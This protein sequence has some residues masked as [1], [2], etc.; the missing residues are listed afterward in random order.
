MSLSNA[1]HLR[2]RMNLTFGG[3][4]GNEESPYSTQKQVAVSEIY[5]NSFDEVL[6]GH[7]SHVKVSFYK[8]GSFEVKDNGRGLPTD[9]S[10]DSNGIKKSGVMLALGTIQAGGKFTQEDSGSYSTGLNGVGASSVMVVADRADIS[11]YRGGKE[12]SLSFKHGEPGFFEGE[13]KD[14]KFKPLG[15]D[16]TK[17]HEA[18]DSR[19]AKDKKNYKTGTNIKVWLDESAFPSPYPFNTNDVIERLRS[20]SFL[21]PELYLEVYSEREE[22]LIEDP[23]TG[24]KEPYHE[25]FHFDEGINELVETLQAKESLTDIHH[26]STEGQYVDTN[27]P[28]FDP[29]TRKTINKNLDRKIEIDVA[30]AYDNGYDS[31]VRTFVNTIHTHNDGVHLTAAQ[32][33]ISKVFNERFSSMRGLIK[34]DREVPTVDDFME[35]ISLVVS[36]KLHEPQFS[37]QSKD[38]LRGREVQ[39]AIRSALI[40]EFEAWIKSSKNK[41]DLDLIAKKVTTASENRQKAKEQRDLNRKKNVLESSTSLPAKLIDC[42]RAGEEEAE[43]YIAEGNS[44]LGSLKGARMS[45]LQALIP[46]RG[47]IINALKET[48]QRVLSN[49][50]VQDIIQTLGAGVGE[51][52]EIEKSRYGKIFLASDEDADGHSINSLLIG[53]LWKMFRPMLEH[54]RVYK[55]ETP[56]FVI[57]T[58]EGK[59]SRHI[60]SQNDRENEREVAKLDNKNI[61]YTVT[62]IKGLGECPDDVLFETAM[63]PETR[64]VTQITFEEFN[65]AE[66]MLELA[67]GKDVPA[68]K[69]W[70]ESL[71]ISEED[72]AE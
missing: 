12:Y 69:K 70:L 26:I 40:K 41:K 20:T 10:V 46:I 36:V 27:A 45:E 9:I 29:E 58:S 63:N 52:F 61:K 7:G 71:E 21:I 13:G 53:L 62:R 23:E 50:E 32:R 25:F 49:Q 11:V 22:T 16:L 54:N 51:N 8:D 1:E 59:K 6:G 56:L 42:D 17:L 34:K 67:L 31:N 14:A 47:K 64:I 55:I 28:V 18:K 66:R 68:R 24:E 19:S 39:S 43:L 2:Q 48:P 30:F 72:L 44:A 35:G 4:S 5:S 60:Y 37:S 57:K 38:E 3:E 33:A 65:K 15:K